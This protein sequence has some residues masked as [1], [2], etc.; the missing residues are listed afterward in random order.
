MADLEYTSKSLRG[1]A[2]TKPGVVAPTTPNTID[3]VKASYIKTLVIGQS[4]QLV[5]G[6]TVL[7]T[8]SNNTVSGWKRTGAQIEIVS[9]NTVTIIF[10]SVAEAVT[11]E[12]RIASCMNGDLV[13]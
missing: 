11:G 1:N 12:E 9:L 5:Q 10:Q 4:F 8:F 6:T 2:G 7:A 3:S 13:V